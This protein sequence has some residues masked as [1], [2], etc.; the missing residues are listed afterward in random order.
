MTQIV[1]VPSSMPRLITIA[2]FQT[3]FGVSRSTV[4]RLFDSRALAPVRI[5][6]SVRIPRNEAERWYRS[7]GHDEA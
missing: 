1:A 5:G 7:L 6:R 3:E 2:Q 4:Y